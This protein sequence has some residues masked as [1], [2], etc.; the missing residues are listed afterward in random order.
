MRT[1][2]AASDRP[3]MSPS[4][5]CDDRPRS[6]RP[7]HPARRA[8][9][10][11]SVPPAAGK[12]TLLR[13]VADLAPPD[14]GHGRACGR[15]I[16]HVSRTAPMSGVVFPELRAVSAPSLSPGNVAFGMKVRAGQE[17]R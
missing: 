17:P 10:R 12:T 4:G 3:P 9:S 11:C 2:S 16:T 8:S 15:D 5:S 7:D 6:Y 14:Q 1:P 13:V